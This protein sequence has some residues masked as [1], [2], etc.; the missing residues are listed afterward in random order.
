ME[1]LLSNFAPMVLPSTNT[2][3]WEASGWMFEVVDM[4]GN[5]IDKILATPIEPS[6]EQPEPSRFSVGKPGERDSTDWKAN[7]L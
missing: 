5:R 1:L 4:D 7:E 2:V 3:S 6:P